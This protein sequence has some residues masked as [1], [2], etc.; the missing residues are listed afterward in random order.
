MK[1]KLKRSILK[2]LIVFINDEHIR[3]LKNALINLKCDTD[4]KY[5]LNTDLMRYSVCSEFYEE[6]GKLVPATYYEIIKDL[7]VLKDRYDTKYQEL[8]CDQFEEILK[9]LKKEVSI[10]HC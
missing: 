3:C 4:F 10:C 7:P 2:Y 1:T 5:E 9:Y 6:Y 8:T